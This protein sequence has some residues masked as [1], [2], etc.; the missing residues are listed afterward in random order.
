M[1]FYLQ[2]SSKCRILEE[3]EDVKANVL[4]IKQ[5]DIEKSIMFYLE[6]AFGNVTPSLRDSTK[7]EM[8]SKLL[9]NVDSG[10]LCIAHDLAREFCRVGRFL[11]TKQLAVSEVKICERSYRR[12]DE[13]TLASMRV[14]AIIFH[15][16]VLRKKAKSLQR[17]VIQAWKDKRDLDLEDLRLLKLRTT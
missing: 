9:D 10:W 13:R 5:A 17:Q 4:Q 8:M 6:N 2:A 3:R 1:I 14:L 16:Q 12:E 11:A 7:A 15:E